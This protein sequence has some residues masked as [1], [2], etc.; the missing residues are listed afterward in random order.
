MEVFLINT[1]RHQIRK[2][3]L[4]VRD[5]TGFWGPINFVRNAWTTAAT[6]HE[7]HVSAGWEFGESL[8]VKFDK[9]MNID[10]YLSSGYEMK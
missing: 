6:L 7:N 8:D 1:S 5:I 2:F 4:P 9:N 3:K 10:E